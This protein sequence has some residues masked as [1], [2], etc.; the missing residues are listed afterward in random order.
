MA[1]ILAKRIKIA[2]KRHKLITR[3]Q[4][5]PTGLFYILKRAGTNQKFNILATFKNAEVTHDAYRS[6]AKIEFAAYSSDLFESEGVER[7]M[8]QVGAI[9][10][11]IAHVQDDGV[12]IM[13]EVLR[14]DGTEPFFSD[15]TY[16]FYAKLIGDTFVPD[17]NE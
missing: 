8:V 16:K 15:D 5:L 14:A 2:A 12:S 13:W 3:V 10:T 6:A 11:H 9:A 4:G 17:D 7:T 1:N